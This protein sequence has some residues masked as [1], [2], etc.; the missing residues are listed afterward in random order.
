MKETGRYKEKKKIVIYRMGKDLIS[1]R[2]S[3][4]FINS[5]FMDDPKKK[6]IRTVLILLSGFISTNFGLYTT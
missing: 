3:F 6:C 4:L 2:G 5:T 1:K